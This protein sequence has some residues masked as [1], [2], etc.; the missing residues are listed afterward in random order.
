MAYTDERGF[1]DTQDNQKTFTEK[2]VDDNTGPYIAQV[3]YNID[4]LKMGRLGVNITALTNT[5]KPTANQ[6]IWC[7]YLSP[8]YG[9]KSIEA[10]A[11]DDPYSYRLTQHSYGMWA[12]PPDIDS[13]VLVL[14]LIHISE[15]TRP[16]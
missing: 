5:N 7:S 6:I 12:V 11:K 10:T 3:K 14:S 8:F 13:K 4:P 2:Y 15:P 9:A 1:V 16:Y